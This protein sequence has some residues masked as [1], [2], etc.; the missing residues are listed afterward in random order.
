MSSE[1]QI[2]KY[3]LTCT[4]KGSGVVVNERRSQELVH[5]AALVEGGEIF[6]H[7]EFTLCYRCNYPNRHS[8]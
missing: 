3:P 1:N 8:T 7:T 4:C 6:S 2:Y 5:L